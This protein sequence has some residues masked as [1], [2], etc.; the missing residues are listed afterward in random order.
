MVCFGG[1]SSLGKSIVKQPT[2]R[3]VSSVEIIM[4]LII[5][6][7]LAVHYKWIS[8]LENRIK[9]LEKHLMEGKQ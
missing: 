1:I 6:I 7:N 9:K 2:K 4:F 8:V 3:R 5:I